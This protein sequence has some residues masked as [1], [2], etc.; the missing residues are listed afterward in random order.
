MNKKAVIIYNPKSGDASFKNVIDSVIDNLQNDYENKTKGYYVEVFRI[1]E[2]GDV[3]EYMKTLGEVDLILGS[4]GDGTINAIISAMIE[5]NLNIPLAIVPSGTANDLATFLKLPTDPIETV[6][7][8][9]R[10]N[11]MPIDIGSVNGIY[12]INVLAVGI[13][14]NISSEVDQELKNV[15]GKLAYY[16]KGAE[17]LTKHEAFNVRVIANDK[18]YEDSFL[19][20]AVLN[21]TNAGGF[22]KLSPD[23]SV[24][25]GLFEF[26]GFKNTTPLKSIKSFIEIINGNHIFDENVLYFKANEIFIDIIEEGR[27]V[28][29]DIDGELGPALPVDIKVLHKKIN[30]FM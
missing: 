23:S 25:D 10:G 29:C 17:K 21:S 8:I 26:I 22:S 24:D 9:H 11:I 28:C 13:F 14:A 30:V 3:F 27:Q 19:L 7:L 6:K 15:I 1:C 4:G 2:Y 5:L 16:L 12:F 18:V 20:L